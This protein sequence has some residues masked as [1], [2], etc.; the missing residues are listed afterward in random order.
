MGSRLSEPQTE[1][2]IQPLVPARPG[3]LTPMSIMIHR[4]VPPRPQ[5]QEEPDKPE[6]VE[7]ASMY[8]RVGSSPMLIEFGSKDH[9]RCC[10]LVRD[11]GQWKRMQTQWHGN[12]KIFGH[13]MEVNF[14]WCVPSKF[15]IKQEFEFHGEPDGTAGLWRSTQRT[16]PPPAYVAIF[17]KAPQSRQRPIYE[18]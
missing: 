17:L 14:R 1:C 6:E 18:V 7:F 15:T 2:I 3:P 5:L 4:A 16:R 12:Y 9:I 13:T 8:C 11:G 10:S